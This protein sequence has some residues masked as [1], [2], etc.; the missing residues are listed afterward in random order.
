MTLHEDE[1]PTNE[2]IIRTL[3][4]AQR[5]DLAGLAI[6][7]VGGGTDNTMYR[8]GEA[9]LVRLPRTREKAAALE[10]E[11]TWLPRLGPRLPFAIPQSL[12]AGRP[13][14]LYPLP[15]AIYTWIDGED[16]ADRTVNDWERY[17]SDLA[18]F[19][20]CLHSTDLMGATRSDGLSGYRGGLLQ[21]KDEW[22]TSCFA[23]ARSHGAELD[24][25]VLERLW[26]EAQSLPEPSAAHVWLHSDLRPAN[27]LV[28]EGRLHAVI[29][30]GGLTVGFPD[31]EHAVTWDLPAAARDAYRNTLDVDDL[32]WLRARAWA[33]AVGISGVSYYWNTFPSFLTECMHRLRA[34]A[35]EAR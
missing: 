4:Y 10:K 34:I 23:K 26:R 17:G 28:R 30:F 21:P 27:V 8:L 19:V 31:A 13:D 5:P 24:F 14:P 33:I 32:T 20:A 2:R 12:H 18:A 1:V 16:L 15:W 22:I 9:Y 7:H 6:A 29:D 3:L 35:A 25:N 11:L